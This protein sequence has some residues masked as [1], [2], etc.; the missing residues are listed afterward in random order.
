MRDVRRR[1][2]EFELLSAAS[3]GR[4]WNDIIDAVFI[5]H[6]HLDHVGALPYFTEV[7]YEDVHVCGTGHPFSRQGHMAWLCGS[8]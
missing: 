5:T 4:P 8:D 2:P 3:G 1:F 7:R 6:F